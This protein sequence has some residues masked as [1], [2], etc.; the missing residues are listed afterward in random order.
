MHVNALHANCDNALHELARAMTAGGRHSTAAALRKLAHAGYTTLEQ[1]ESTPDWILLAIRGIG[2]GRLGEVRRLTRPDWQPPSP[3]A[4]Q[5][6]NWFLSATRFALRY[7]PLETLA[8]WIWGS[9]PAMID[10]VSVER[11]LALD[12]FSQA[13]R[14]ALSHCTPQDLNEM[15]RLARNG[16][17]PG[18]AQQA[19]GLH[20]GAAVQVEVISSEQQKESGP[21]TFRARPGHDDAAAES[22]RYAYSPRKRCEIVQHY[23]AVRDDGL[24]QNKDRWAQSNYNITG[25]TLL[26]YER[27]FP[28]AQRGAP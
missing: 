23:R 28:E 20:N 16:H 15:L 4:I 22:D 21:E 13:S 12:V 26:N 17:H 1:V 14:K 3:Q 6:A 25:R 27:E 18:C 24:V 7:W 9:A 19:T 2:V 5:T 10:R 8:S 11:Q